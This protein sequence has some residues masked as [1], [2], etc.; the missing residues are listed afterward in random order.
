MTPSIAQSLSRLR[1]AFPRED[2]PDRTVAVYGQEL[3]DLP[4][5]AVA[6]AVENVIRRARFLPRVS[7]IIAQVAEMELNLPTTEQAWEIAERGSLRDAHHIVR[8]AAEFVGGRWVI[9]HG[10]NPTATRAQFRTAYDRLR[11]RT[12][13]EYETGHALPPPPGLQVLGPTMAALPETDRIR[14]RPVMARLH[15]HWAGHELDPPTDEEKADA[16]DILREGPVTRDPVMDPLYAM[17][18]RI[19]AEAGLMKEET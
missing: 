8:E 19:F 9:L 15:H 3:A 12:L 10:D 5:E 4:P 1:D 18:E 7:E 11:E 17:A 14:P 2:F 16:V 13:A 6:R